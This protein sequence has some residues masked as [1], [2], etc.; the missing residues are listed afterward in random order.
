MI[1]VLH[2]PTDPTIGIARNQSI[3]LQTRR[4]LV[5][6]ARDI[7]V[8]VHVLF[9]GYLGDAFA[10]F[11]PLAGLVRLP[12]LLQVGGR[13]PVGRRPLCSGRVVHAHVHEAQ[14]FICM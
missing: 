9:L 11:T 5:A 4:D 3:A 14:P 12:V 13:A 6:G 10:S 7:K 1:E 2:T 8:H